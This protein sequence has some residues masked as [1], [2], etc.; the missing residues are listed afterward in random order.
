V[1]RTDEG[2]AVVAERCEQTIPFHSVLDRIMGPVPADI[3]DEGGDTEKVLVDGAVAGQGP[4]YP[5]G[6][7]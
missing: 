1:G 3:V 2:F 6:D 5:L 4:A 7:G